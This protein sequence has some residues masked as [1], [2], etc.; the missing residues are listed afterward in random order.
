M[1]HSTI[2]INIWNLIDSL[3]VEHPCSRN[4]TCI[5][6]ASV[7]R[8][9]CSR[10]WSYMVI[11]TIVA[12]L[13]DDERSSAHETRNSLSLERKIELSWSCNR[14]YCMHSLIFVECYESRTCWAV[15]I[16][17]RLQW[18]IVWVVPPNHSSPPPISLYVADTH[19]CAWLIWPF[20]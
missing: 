10:L 13:P 11:R 20:K 18:V 6:S 7:H 5:F 8:L 17:Q 9:L 12:N 4:S 14:H 1:I 15:L 16:R 3:K 2:N 19:D